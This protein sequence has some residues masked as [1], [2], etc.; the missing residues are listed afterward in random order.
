LRA[1]AI[2]KDSWKRILHPV[3][4]KEQDTFNYIILPIL[5]Y[6]ILYYIILYYI[7]LY[8]IWNWHLS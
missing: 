3:G 2:I 6:I 8:Y 4:N 1:G 5:Y 7:I